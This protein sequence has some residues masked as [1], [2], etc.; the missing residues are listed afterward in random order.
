MPARSSGSDWFVQF[1]A[2]Q[3]LHDAY[4]A[5][6][7]ERGIRAGVVVAGIGMVEDPEL[8]FFDGQRYHKRR[9]PG[10]HELVSTQGNVAMLEGEPF[11]HLHVSIAGRDHVALAGHLFEGAVHISHEGCLRVL[12]GVALT[13]ERDP[14]TQLAS[15][16]W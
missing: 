3:Q 8:G 6:A 4:R 2:G 9:F 10:A 12:E 5:F 16:R 14:A 1:E 13:R 11:T 7:R 15:L